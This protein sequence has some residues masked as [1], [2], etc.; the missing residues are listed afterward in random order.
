[1]KRRVRRIGGA[2]HGLVLVALS[3]SWCFAATGTSGPPGNASAAI[4]V[5]AAKGDAV[6]E[7][8]LMELERS[9]AQ[10]RMD[11]VPAPYYIEYR[12]H[13]LEDYA[14]EAAWG[15]LR[16]DQQYRLRVL[17]AVVRVGDYKQDSYF[18]QGVGETEL[19]P[20]DNDPI[21]LRH[22]IWL[23]TDRAY[24]AASEALTQKQALLKQFTP[25]PNAPDDFAHAPVLQWLGPLVKLDY[26][27]AKWHKALEDVSGLY[28]QYP[29]VQ[30]VEASLRFT[31]INEYFVNSEGTVTRGGQTT[32]TVNLSGSAQA[33]DGMR[34]G[35]TPYWMVARA[36]E[37]PSP[38]E[39]RKEG[40]KMLDSLMQLRQAPLVEEEYRGPVLF[41]ADS[42]DDIFASLIGTNVLGRKPAPGRPNRT[43]GAF[44]TSLK[45]RVLPPFLS[46]VDNP[47]MKDF[48]GHSLVGS[49]EVDSDGV[50]AAPVTVI[51]QGILV[52]YLM[53]RQPIRDFPA[54]NGHGRAAPGVFPQP[55][56]GNL[57]VRASQTATP[58]ELKKRMLEIVRE[59]DK[60][61]GY[62]VET[63]GP[64]N[65]P[66]LLYR[67]WQKDG[68]QELVRGAVFNELDVR[69]L[70]NNLIAA[71]NDPLVSN[72]PGGYPTS[73]VAPSVL[74]DELEVKRAD[75]SKEKLPEYPPPALTK[76]R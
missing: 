5:A 52:N 6:L 38:E 36:E 76:P 16:Q 37:L 18:G 40:V 53:G 46:V 17:R 55:G 44:G 74:F 12:V 70:R 2:V 4:D 20:L 51:D 60:P 23:A 72:R 30:T 26:D 43:M 33:L 48:Q 47:T 57:L 10:L 13:E 61:Y 3:W 59:Q 8:L 25:E 15:V 68:R 64:G 65:S 39:L 58:E 71:G 27:A 35:R 14:A 11:N 41:S 69:T 31:A 49:Y 32:Y 54:S 24:K 34:L 42:A 62:F 75:T 67:M 28:R 66:R 45:S 7:A 56:L 9:K 19:L 21:A 50:R 29:D 1:M 73:V 63:L 22:Q